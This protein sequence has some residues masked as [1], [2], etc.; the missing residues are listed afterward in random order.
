MFA[1]TKKVPRMRLAL[2]M[3][4][5]HWRIQ[6]P[7]PIIRGRRMSVTSVCL[8]SLFFTLQ[9]SQR[10]AS[11]IQM[12]PTHSRGAREPRHGHDVYPST[13]RQGAVSA[14]PERDALIVNH[15]KS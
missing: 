12:L 5:N 6:F 4:I 13:E 15:D 2:K 8:F 7:P 14:P 9:L 11:S 3:P 10:R 1:D